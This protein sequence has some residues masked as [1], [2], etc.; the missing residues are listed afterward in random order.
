MFRGTLVLVAHSRVAPGKCYLYVKTVERAH[1][2]K[3]LWEKIRVRSGGGGAVQS[4]PGPG[5]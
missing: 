1:S 2:P 4:A 3:N 5:P